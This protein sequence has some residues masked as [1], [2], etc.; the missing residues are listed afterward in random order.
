MNFELSAGWTY[1]VFALYAVMAFTALVLVGVAVDF[2]R[3]PHRRQI[4]GRESNHTHNRQLIA[5]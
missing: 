2:V 4:V 5:H 1:V 3:Q